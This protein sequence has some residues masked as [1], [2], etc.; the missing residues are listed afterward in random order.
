LDDAAIRADDVNAVQVRDSLS[1]ARIEVERLTALNAGKGVRYVA[2]PTRFIEGK[3]GE[4]GTVAPAN[5][6]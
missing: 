3:P 1:D 6:T 4:P 5:E 2:I